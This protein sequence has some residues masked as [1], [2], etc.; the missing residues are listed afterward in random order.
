MKLTDVPVHTEHRVVRLVRVSSLIAIA[1]GVLA[2]LSRIT[3][4]PGLLRLAPGDAFG[5]LFIGFAIR[6]SRLADYRPRFRVMLNTCRYSLL[7][8]GVAGIAGLRIVGD[9]SAPA[10]PGFASGLCFLLAAAILLLRRRYT[11]SVPANVLCLF[12]VACAGACW[13][14]LILFVAQIAPVPSVFAIHPLLLATLTLASLGLSAFIRNPGVVQLIAGR[15]IETDVARGL[16]AASLGVPVLVA[17]FSRFAE[18]AGWIWHGDAI[19]VQVLISV[20]CM[21]AVTA[22][23]GLRVFILR[24]SVHAMHVHSS[25]NERMYRQILESLDEPIWIFGS[26]GDV[27]FMNSSARS[28]SEPDAADWESVLDREQ[29]HSVLTA[30]LFGYTYPKLR[31]R[32]SPS[33]TFQSLPVRFLG[34]FAGERNAPEQIVLVA[35]SQPTS[36]S[37]DPSASRGLTGLEHLS[38]GPAA[39][40]TT[41]ELGNYA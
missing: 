19:L 34:V 24:R 21:V 32:H 23:H 11:P 40:G 1:V 36:V 5:L 9:P 10:S 22:V 2:L 41:P 12:F 7:L 4:L 31:L 8:L 3:S 37:P 26:G 16:F 20:G 6:L 15:G 33:G 13:I 17:L 18:E 27:S 30:A 14:A 35:N 38:S 28:F 39:P 29:Q 25:E